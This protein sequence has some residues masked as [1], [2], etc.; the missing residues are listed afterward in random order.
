[1]FLEAKSR[2]SNVDR[3]AVELLRFGRKVHPKI[4]N[5]A[6]D[7]IWHPKI[8]ASNVETAWVVVDNG[9]SLAGACKHRC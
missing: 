5:D 2:A 7:V 8:L 6:G 1:L 9:Y 3:D 4:F